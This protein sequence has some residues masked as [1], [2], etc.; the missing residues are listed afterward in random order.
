MAL[1]KRSD[2]SLSG[3]HSISNITIYSKNIKFVQTL[4]KSEVLFVLK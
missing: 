2:K 1:E 4:S 3:I